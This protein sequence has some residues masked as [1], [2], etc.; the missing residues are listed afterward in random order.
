MD[1]E[2]RRK[3]LQLQSLKEAIQEDTHQY[4]SGEKAE[5]RLWIYIRM[6]VLMIELLPYEKNR[7]EALVEIVNLQKFITQLYL[8]MVHPKSVNK[9]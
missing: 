7:S 2:I 8:T 3:Y 5:L 6:V 9:N 4:L 1:E